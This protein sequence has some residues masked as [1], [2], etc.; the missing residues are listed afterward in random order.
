[1]QEESKRERKIEENVDER[2]W[3][4]KVVKVVYKTDS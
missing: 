4:E 1:M 3:K 2:D